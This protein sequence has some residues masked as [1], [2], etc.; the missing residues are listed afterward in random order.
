MSYGGFADEFVGG[1]GA[2]IVLDIGF[3]RGL[4]ALEGNA[5]L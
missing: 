4:V 3:E 2:E 1:C 5:G